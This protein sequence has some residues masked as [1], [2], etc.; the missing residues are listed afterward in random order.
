MK[1][2]PWYKDYVLLPPKTAKEN[3]AGKSFSLITQ[4]FIFLAIQVVVFFF[5]YGLFS[6]CDRYMW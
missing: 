2:S 6:F 3:F 1:D 4:L 5:T